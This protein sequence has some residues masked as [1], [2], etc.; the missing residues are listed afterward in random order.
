MAMVRCSHPRRAKASRIIIPVWRF[1]PSC[2]PSPR[3]SA[4]PRRCVPLPAVSFPNLGARHRGPWADASVNRE[5][6][7]I[8]VSSLLIGG[9]IVQAQNRSLMWSATPPTSARSSA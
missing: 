2:G 8:P 4:L 3:S 1:L 6:G 9:S 7:G 5:A